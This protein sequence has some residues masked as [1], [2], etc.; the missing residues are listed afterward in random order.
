MNDERTGNDR[1]DDARAGRRE[2]DVAH[3]T[4]EEHDALKAAIEHAAKQSVWTLRA[5]AVVVVAMA[6]AGYVLFDGLGDRADDIQAQADANDAQAD[7]LTAQADAIAA[8]T[9]A[10]ERARRYSIVVTCRETNERHRESFKALKHLSRDAIDREPERAGE[11]RQS[12]AAFRLFVNALVPLRDCQARA[13]ELT[14]PPPPAPP[15][16]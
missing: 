5:I 16:R 4:R 12:T 3:V 11:I 10:I 7:A 13:D 14:A 8:Q 1:R 9:K 15:P 6:V 2:S